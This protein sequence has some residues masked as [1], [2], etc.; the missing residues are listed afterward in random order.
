MLSIRELLMDSNSNKQSIHRYGFLYDMLLSYITQVKGDTANVL[1]IGV[2]QYENGSL[3]VWKKFEKVNRVVGVDIEHLPEGQIEGVAF[4]KLDGYSRETVDHLLEIEGPKF[5]LIIHDGKA[6]SENHKFFLDNYTDLLSDTGY[7]VCEDVS[8]TVLIME[9]CKDDNVFVIDGWANIG[10]EVKGFN[11]PKFYNHSERIV[12]KSKSDMLKEGKK[13]ETKPHIARL[14]TVAFETKC[15]RNSKELAVSIPLFHSELD[16]QYENFNMER[17]KNV[18]CKGAVWAGMSLLKNTDLAE[19]GVPLYFHIEDK[20]WDASTEVLRSYG[21]P[22]SWCRKMVAPTPEKEPELRVNK[23]QFG[24]TYLGLMDDDID[25]DALLI[26][27]SDFFTCTDGERLKF[28]DKLTSPMLK[29]QPSM[30]HFHLKQLPY[31]FY[32]SLFLLASGLPDQLIGKRP[33]AELEKEAFER[34]GFDKEVDTSLIEKDFVFRFFT[35]NYMTTFPREHPARDFAI[36]HISTCHTAPYLFS[37]WG[38]FNQPFI[39][40]APLLNIPIYDW[41]NDYIQGEKGDQCFAHFRVNK[42]RHR[43][44]SNPTR[45]HKYFDRFYENLSRHVV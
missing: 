10:V 20:V 2:S 4:Y 33:I 39:E 13:H 25:T 11:D 43:S 34:L 40:L 24:K 42:A 27:D 29:K 37:M 5:D 12:I 38:E 41:E 3:F 6:R 1:E 9:Q 15:S 32:T 21:I 35:E 19:N 23:T 45:I 18:H 36:K 44:L 14:P 7:L 17:F 28:Y 26:L 22:E 16:T 8:S 30:T 31:Y